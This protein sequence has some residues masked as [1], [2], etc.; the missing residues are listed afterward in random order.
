MAVI[1]D[2]PTV[3]FISLLV[4]L[5]AAMAI[6]AFIL[7]HRAPL[8]EEERDD[9]SVVQTSTLTLLALLIGFSL[10]MAV[11]RYDQRK[12]LEE[13]EA[14]AIGTQYARADLT[15]API[16]AQMKAALVRYTQL[17]LAD[18]YTR[19]PDELTRIGRETAQVQAELWRL[20]TQVAKTNR[21]PSPPSSQAG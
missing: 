21:H 7:R 20:A 10:S 1:V 11:N 8:P 5:V 17:R 14:N 4:L 16:S 6:G 15:D 13:S 9:F 3:L 2:Y 18:Y 19:N 12:S